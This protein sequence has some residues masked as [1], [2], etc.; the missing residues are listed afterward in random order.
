MHNA[1]YPEGTDNDRAFETE[2]LKG[3][4]IDE[5]YDELQ[6]WNELGKNTWDI[7]D[8]IFT[9]SL[10]SLNLENKETHLYFILFLNLLLLEYYS[11]LVPLGLSR[12]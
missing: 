6:Y 3:L 7:D 12:F 1:K 8:E 9:I 5:L 10:M 2:R 11:I 4:N